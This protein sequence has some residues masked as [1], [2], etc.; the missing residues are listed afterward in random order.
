MSLWECFAKGFGNVVACLRIVTSTTAGC[1]T[2]PPIERCLRT[3]RRRWP[4]RSP[5]FRFSTIGNNVVAMPFY[6][7]CAY[8]KSITSP[9][10]TARA[11]LVMVMV[12]SPTLAGRP[13]RTNAHRPGMG[14]CVGRSLLNR[15]R[16]SNA[17]VRV[18]FTFSIGSHR[19]RATPANNATP[20]DR[21]GTNT[22]VAS[23]LIIPSAPAMM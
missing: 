14:G 17:S 15:G 9:V 8:I 22:K 1:T 13:S 18:I 21:G 7:V 23:G 11:V 12:T 19:V 4:K 6:V 3:R 16:C 2:S 10:G 20:M 5:R